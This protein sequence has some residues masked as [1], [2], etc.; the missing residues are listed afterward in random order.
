MKNFSHFIRKNLSTILM[1]LIMLY[2]SI[3]PSIASATTTAGTK[4]ITNVICLATNELTGPVGRAIAIVII[5]SLAISLFLGKV[6]WGLAI[7]TIIG[8]SILFGAK[9]L[10]NLLTANTT[11]IC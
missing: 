1:C 7:A 2:G 10:V 4:A 5:A 3:L 9:D 6:S 8:L 11:A